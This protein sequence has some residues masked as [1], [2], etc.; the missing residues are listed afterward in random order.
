MKTDDVLVAAVGTAAF[1]VAF[2]VLL[3]VP[4]DPADRWWRWVCVTGFAMGAF[5]CWYIPRLQK[6]RADAAARRTAH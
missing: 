1:A 5:G 2:V 4:L 6:G 3:L